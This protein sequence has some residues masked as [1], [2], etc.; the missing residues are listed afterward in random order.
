MITG[1]FTAFFAIVLAASFF[2]A[3]CCWDTWHR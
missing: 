3:A 1:I 2:L